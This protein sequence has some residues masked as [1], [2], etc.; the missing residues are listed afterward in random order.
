MRCRIAATAMVPLFGNSMIFA[1]VVESPQQR[2]R[3]PVLRTPPRT[4]DSA[5]TR[6]AFDLGV[7]DAELIRFGCGGS[8]LLQKGSGL[9]IT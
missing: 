2:S 4:E 3:D 7:A 6:R 8:L 1:G 9:L 5:S